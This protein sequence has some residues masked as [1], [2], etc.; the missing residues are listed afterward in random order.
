MGTMNDCYRLAESRKEWLDGDAWFLRK[1]TANDKAS[2]IRP[3]PLLPFPWKMHGLTLTDGARLE[4]VCTD[5]RG[6]IPTK[7]SE[8]VEVSSKTKPVTLAPHR[9]VNHVI[10]IE[11]GYQLPY[12]RIYNISEVEFRTLK[13]Y[14]E[15][16]LANRFIQRSASPA[17]APILF[18][19]NKDCGLR[20]CVDYRALNKGLVKNRY[21]LPLI[22]VMLDLLCGGRIFT[23]LDVRNAYLLNQIKEG[24]E[25]QTAFRT[26]YGQFECRVMPFRLINT[27]ATF[28]SYIDDCLRPYIDDFAV[29]Y[30]DGI[31]IY[32]TNEMEHDEHVRK[33]LERLREFGL[34]CKD[35]KYQF[36]VTEV[37]ILGF[38]INSHGIGMELVRIATI[39][40]W[41]MPKSIRDVQV[42]L[43]FANF[44]RRFIRKYAKVTL[45]FT[46]LLKT[47]TGTA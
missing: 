24:D 45:P 34:Y 35:K 44:H 8:F 13:A 2:W 36:G 29:C 15:T 21:A 22:S 27:P 11:A 5:D 31:L 32:S 7:Y 12:G 23:K 39:E 3:L 43:G 41:P 30:L 4:R 25:Y 17:A 18:T 46:E 42:L 40:D 10:D 16:N 19:K 26:R 37:G 6:Y 20:L 9:H 33:V 14:C 47:T 38:L 1:R 28:Q